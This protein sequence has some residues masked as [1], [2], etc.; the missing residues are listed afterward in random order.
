MGSS[1][2][3]SIWKPYRCATGNYG[4]FA[5]GRSVKQFSQ[6]GLGFSV[7]LRG[8]LVVPPNAIHFFQAVSERFPYVCLVSSKVFPGLVSFLFFWS[9]FPGL[10]GFNLAFQLRG[11]GGEQGVGS[12][13]RG[14]RNTKEPFTLPSTTQMYGWLPPSVARVTLEAEDHPPMLGRVE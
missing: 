12:V 14:L 4:A 2:H 10:L 7:I 11:E 9:G 6:C 8:V 5:D 1:T 3:L 13:G